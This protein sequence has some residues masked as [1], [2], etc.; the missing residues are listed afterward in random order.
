MAAAELP[1][2]R[3]LAALA[4]TRRDR[5]AVARQRERQALAARRRAGHERRDMEIRREPRSRHRSGR[6]HDTRVARR[7]DPLQ[8]QPAP[9]RRPQAFWLRADEVV[10]AAAVSDL[11]FDAANTRCPTTLG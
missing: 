7:R 9:G 2:R 1:G 8:Q 5:A 3:D 4:G 10:S 11:N 6:A